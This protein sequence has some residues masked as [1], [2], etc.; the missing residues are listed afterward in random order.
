MIFFHEKSSAQDRTINSPYAL[1]RSFFFQRLTDQRHKMLVFFEQLTYA[2]T[3]RFFIDALRRMQRF[4]SFF[5]E[6]WKI[7]NVKNVKTILQKV[8]YGDIENQKCNFRGW[9]YKF[10]GIS[11]YFFK[12]ITKRSSK[13]AFFVK[14]YEICDFGG[15]F[16]KLS[17]FFVASFR[18]NGWESSPFYSNFYQKIPEKREMSFCSSENKNWTF[19]GSFD[20]FFYSFFLV[21]NIY[22]IKI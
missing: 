17:A 18:W 16:D 2:H 15:W 1:I 8:K 11:G 9:F 7:K 3:T 12:K 19:R 4:Y 5:W 10:V 21:K 6:M 13:F 20:I 14:K 22:L